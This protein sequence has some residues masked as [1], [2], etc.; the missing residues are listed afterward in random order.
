MNDLDMT[1]RIKV[2]CDKLGWGNDDQCSDEEVEARMAII[3]DED[4]QLWRQMQ[5]NIL[6]HAR[7]ADE[8]S[9]IDVDKEIK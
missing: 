4:P 6:E 1:K 8:D 9:I 5:D 3:R 7:A 2:V